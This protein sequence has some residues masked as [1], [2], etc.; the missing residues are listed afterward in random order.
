[1]LHYY[2]FINPV[3][4]SAG[5]TL[6]W[7]NALSAATWPQL[8]VND[9]GV[10][11]QL[12]EPYV[13]LR[14]FFILGCRHPHVDPMYHNIS[15]RMLRVHIIAGTRLDGVKRIAPTQANRPWNPNP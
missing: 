10:S 14:S 11:W 3:G 1:M 2:D 4:Y 9:K 6:A 8:A 12:I 15:R 13:L 7:L 5:K